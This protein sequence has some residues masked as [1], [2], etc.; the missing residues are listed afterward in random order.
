MTNVKQLAD[1]ALTHPTREHHL[2][3]VRGFLMLLGIPFHAA[4]PFR[5]DGEKWLAVASQRSEALTNAIEFLHIFRMQGFFLIAGYFS[6]LLIN[7]WESDRFFKARMTRLLPPLIASLLVIVPIMNLISA[8][9]HYS[10]SSAV[11]FWRDQM[12]RPGRS[13]VGHLWFVVVLIYYTVILWAAA[14]IL[15]PIRQLKSSANY[16]I[17]TTLFLAIIIAVGIIIGLYETCAAK[18]LSYLPSIAKELS[19]INYAAEYAPY[20]IMGSILHRMSFLNRM[21]NKFSW[22]IAALATGGCVSVVAFDHDLPISLVRIIS[23]ISAIATTQVI[24]SGSYSLFS[25]GKRWVRELV[26][27]SFVIYLFHLPIIIASVWL[28]ELLPLPLVGRYIALC[29]IAISGSLIA[30]LFVKRFAVTRF[31]F[32][33]VPKTKEG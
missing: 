2:D 16:N 11:Y 12:M 30:W 28:V 6:A 1:G 5:A 14:R 31:W 26:D 25:D 17:P 4:H 33:G 9:Q 13:A 19:S 18:A 22:R 8:M 10:F 7:R 24:V 20:F 21:F 29:I 15:T 23:A 32:S 27:A 3:A